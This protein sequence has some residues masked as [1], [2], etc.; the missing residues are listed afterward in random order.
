MSPTRG[1]CSQGFTLLEML[2]VIALT[3]LVLTA[4]ADYYLDLSRA[5]KEAVVKI[6]ETRRAAR[7][8]DRL[9]RELEG[10]TLIVKPPEMDP[11]RWPW[12][13]YAEADDESAGARRV[14]FL[15]R[16]YRPNAEALREQDL[17]MVSY[18]AEE[19]EE[20][21]LRLWRTA[22]PRL[23][24]ELDLSFP[25]GETEGARLLS[26]DLA[27][28]GMRFLTEDGESVARFDSSSLVESGQL[29]LAVEIEIAFR[30]PDDDGGW[31]E[32]PSYRRRVAL[33]VRP[34]DIEEELTAA[35]WFDAAH[36]EDEEKTEENAEGDGDQENCVR[37][38][39]CAASN[40]AL[41]QAARAQF[42]SKAV[43]QFLLANDCIDSLPQQ[44]RAL[45]Q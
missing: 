20:G 18:V 24:E 35:G 17:A 1:T 21:G 29:P 22:S 28:F 37:V 25:R 43:D 3:A 14:K 11:I 32:G 6:Q 10:A 12:V 39:E 4:A 40:P 26:E 15:T 2:A 16:G 9:A 38:A 7:L 33:P 8:L 13:F 23:P 36:G 30:E 31:V 45:C 5:Q 27:A 34:L 41:E 44:L 42:G 19:D